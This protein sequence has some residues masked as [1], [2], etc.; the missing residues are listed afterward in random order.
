MRIGLIA[1]KAGVLGIG[2]VE[3]HL[4]IDTDRSHVFHLW[5]VGLGGAALLRAEVHMTPIRVEGFP[6][7]PGYIKIDIG[8]VLA[9]ASMVPFEIKVQRFAHRGAP[10]I[11]QFE[12]STRV[13][14]WGWAPAGIKINSSTRVIGGQMG[15]G[16]WHRIFD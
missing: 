11:V 16:W 7:H 1:Q 3:V 2:A 5:H 6:T 8:S 4:G 13:E 10:P 12:Y 14:A 9:Y 15:G